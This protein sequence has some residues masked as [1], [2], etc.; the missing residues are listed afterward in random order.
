VSGLHTFV[1]GVHGAVRYKY[2]CFGPAVGTRLKSKRRMARTWNT[3]KRDAQ[4]CFLCLSCNHSC[5]SGSR[6]TWSAPRC[7]HVWRCMY[8]YTYLYVYTSRIYLHIF[9]C[10]HVHIHA[11]LHAYVCLCVYVRST[12]ANVLACIRMHMMHTCKFLQAHVH[13]YTYMST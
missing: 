11:C 6:Y 3:R 1:R 2:V 5:G 8:M 7:V 9:V 10:L 13:I 12:H 4:G